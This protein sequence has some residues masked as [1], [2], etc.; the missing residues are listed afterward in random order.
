MEFFHSLEAEG[1][2][3]EKHQG[4]LQGVGLCCR[5]ALSEMG[6]TAR[7]NVQICMEKLIASIL[8]P[9]LRLI[10]DVYYIFL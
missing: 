8:S 1:K 10:A 9:Q 5:R 4:L 2:E 6:K 3:K 7:N